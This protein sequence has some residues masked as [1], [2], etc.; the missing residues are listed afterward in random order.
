MQRAQVHLI[1][2]HNMQSRSI[3]AD[4]AFP[5][6]ANAVRRQHIFT[7]AY[8]NLLH[9]LAEIHPNTLTW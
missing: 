7:N 8:L 9:S 3:L 5:I 1:R 2:K 4:P 6:K